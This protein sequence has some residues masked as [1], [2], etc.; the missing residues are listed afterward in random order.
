MLRSMINHQMPTE[1]INCHRRRCSTKTPE[2][3]ERR[4]VIYWIDI[5]I[6][7]ESEIIVIEHDFDIL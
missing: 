5:G 4:V 6:S 7:K 3:G 2:I 1:Q